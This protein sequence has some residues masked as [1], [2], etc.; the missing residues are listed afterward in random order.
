M[1]HSYRRWPVHGSALH[2]DRCTAACEAH[3]NLADELICLLADNVWNEVVTIHRSRVV[4]QMP[5][6]LHVDIPRT[7][8]EV[9]IYHLELLYRNTC[10]FP[11]NIFF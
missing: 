10:N 6:P 4:L 9:L 1:V 5:L 8:G 2:G 7:Q 11:T 3:T